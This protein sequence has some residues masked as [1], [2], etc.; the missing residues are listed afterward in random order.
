MDK[1]GGREGGWGRMKTKEEGGMGGER[2]Y[3]HIVY[4]YIGVCDGIPW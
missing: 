3:I 2:K 1:H 4:M